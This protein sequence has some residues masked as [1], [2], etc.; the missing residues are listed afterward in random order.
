MIQ[1]RS[2]SILQILQLH[3][4][5]CIVWSAW[6]VKSFSAPVFVVCLTFIGEKIDHYRS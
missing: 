4:N 6:N 3:L 5:F 2:K 1:L